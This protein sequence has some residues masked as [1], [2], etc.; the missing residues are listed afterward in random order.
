[1]MRLAPRYD[2]IG[3]LSYAQHP[4]FFDT[5][6]VD[7]LGE[8]ERNSPNLRDETDALWRKFVAAKDGLLEER[9]KNGHEEPP[10]SWRKLYKVSRL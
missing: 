6:P 3:D 4:L 9:V 7:Q 5:R 8:L 2:D 10:K 1:M